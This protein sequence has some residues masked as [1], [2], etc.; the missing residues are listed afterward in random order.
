MG[1]LNHEA[2]LDAICH[3]GVVLSY[4]EA[5]EGYLEL[6]GLKSNSPPSPAPIEEAQPCDC[7]ECLE[8][9]I[10]VPS[11]PGDEIVERVARAIFETSQD[12]GVERLPVFTRHFWEEDRDG[13]GFRRLAQAAILEYRGIGSASTPEGERR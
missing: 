9:V 3:T 5:I 6:R 13:T 12:I 7:D 2:A 11:D 4:Q 1:H 10:S 8:S